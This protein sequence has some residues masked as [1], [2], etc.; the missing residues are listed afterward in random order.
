MVLLNKALSTIRTLPSYFI[1]LLKRL[2][3]YMVIKAMSFLLRQ[4]RLETRI[5]IWISTQDRLSRL[6]RAHGVIGLYSD[7]QLDTTTYGMTQIEQRI[8]NSI[9]Y[10][11]GY[12]K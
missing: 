12:D 11:K 5:L 7:S 6:L 9:S 4:P 3:R 1:Y 10:F 2:I 8:Y